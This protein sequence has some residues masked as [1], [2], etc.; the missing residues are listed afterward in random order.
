MLPSCLSSRC[1]RNIL[2]SA[3]GYRFA[4]M[5]RLRW[6]CLFMVCLLPVGTSLASDCEEP[7]ADTLR[8]GLV[9]GGSPVTT[10]IACYIRPLVR[11]SGI[12]ISYGV[13]GIVSAS[14]SGSDL[15]LVPAYV[16]SAAP[17]Q[18]TVT[19]RDTVTVSSASGSVVVI[20]DVTS[21]VNA[22]LQIQSHTD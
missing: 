11:S 22:S 18:D 10:S 19:G 1:A 7:A 9:A 3:T 5:K 8:I 13:S 4:I 15:T 21:C 14:V 2:A 12:E 17:G 16:T 6:L 20:V